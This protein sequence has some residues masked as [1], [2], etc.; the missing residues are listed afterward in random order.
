MNTD[1]IHVEHIRTGMVHGGMVHRFRG[2]RDY[3]ARCKGYWH[4]ESEYR[5]TSAPITCRQCRAAD[6]GGVSPKEAEGASR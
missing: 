3:V 1:N 4:P 2:R 5:P 6:R